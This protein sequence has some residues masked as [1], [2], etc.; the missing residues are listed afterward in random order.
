MCRESCLL[1]LEVGLGMEELVADRNRVLMVETTVCILQE[2]EWLWR[3]FRG[4]WVDKG[5]REEYFLARA[6]DL[7]TRMGVKKMVNLHCTQLIPAMD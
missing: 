1:G 7:V 6:S 4:Y 5:S 3:E 2:L